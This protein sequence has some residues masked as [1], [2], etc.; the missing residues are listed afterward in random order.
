[1]VNNKRR[2]VAVFGGLAVILIFLFMSRSSPEPLDVAKP[3]V[4]VPERSK[5]SVVAPT[6]TVPSETIPA[7]I[8]VEFPDPFALHQPSPG[9]KYVTYL[10]HSGF[11]NQRI[12]LENAFL[13][14]AYLNRTLLLPSVFLGNPA[15]PWLRYNKM[16]ERLLL[17]TKRGL[18][19]C[20]KIPDDMP[21]PSECLNYFR[22]TSVPWTFFY[23]FSAIRERIR[24]IFRDDL[25]YEWMYANLNITAKQIHFMKD[26]S[27]YE[28]RVY[29][30]PQSQTKLAK[31]VNRIDLVTLEAIQEP[32][33]HFGSVF[34]TYRVLAQTEEH[35]ELLKFLRTHMILRNP[36][37]VDTA[38]RVVTKLGGVSGFVGLHIR[39]GDGLFKRRASIHVDDIFHKMVD[40]FTDLTLDQLKQ[41]DSNHDNDR[42]ENEDYEVRQLR[43][44]QPIEDSF[45]PLAV[46]HP[47]NVHTYV[48]EENRLDPALT[49]QAGDSITRRFRKTVVYIA[50]D[51]PNP[52]NNPLLK[53]I[54]ATF[55]CVFVLSDFKEELTDM[56]RIEVVHEKIKLESYLIPMVDAIIAAQGHTFLGTKDSTFSSYIERQLHPV[57]TNKEVKVMKPRKKSVS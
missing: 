20:P 52:R 11:H 29:D 37:L 41:Y 24:I 5:V 15:M 6:A 48:G 21:F 39:V 40:S 35:A 17:Q 22:W 26:R 56:K 9:E 49:C 42:L 27:P 32:V 55:P 28:F 10:P 50:T 46:D 19:H 8:A 1:M 16:Y 54:F 4:P 14:A 3:I 36:V 51:A 45:K 57:Y 47:D 31:F 38:T 30:D 23:D 44:F 43:Q 33:L 25:S 7:P 13:L 53:K 2:A 18:E 34:G 12:E